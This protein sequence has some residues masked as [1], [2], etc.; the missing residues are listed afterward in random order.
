M[1]TIVCVPIHRIKCK[2]HV[3]Q[4]RAWTAVEELVLAAIAQQPASIAELS[5]ASKLPHQII[6]YAIARLMRFRFAAVEVAEG[7]EARFTA[8]SF[9]RTAIES[10]DPLPFFP[11][12]ITRHIGITVDRVT[13]QVFSVRDVRLIRKRDLEELQKRKDRRTLVLDV[14]GA[15]LSAGHDAMFER[16]AA[17]VE[18]GQEEMLAYVDASTVSIWSN[19]EYMAV[20]VEDGI[21]LDLPVGTS[22]D[23]RD[24]VLATAADSS[25]RRHISI[26]YAGRETDDPVRTAISC[27]FSS[28]DIV[29]GGS[30]KQLLTELIS[31]ANRRVIVHSTFIGKDCVEELL[32]IMHQACA[33]GVL[34][35][36][37]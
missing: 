31:T 17:F 11:K 20:S 6:A 8:S 5:H 2:V 12:R 10:G 19:T 23:L 37:L 9:G 22:A 7:G 14:T 34:I 32:A 3:D 15:E 13:G 1:T 28:D 24:A 18:R 33:R 27:Q 25:G 26:P 29:I 35:D 30:Q 4:G 36:L 21:C 16:L